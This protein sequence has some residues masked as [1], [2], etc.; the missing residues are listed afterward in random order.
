MK[1]FDFLKKA[2]LADWRFR[3]RILGVFLLI[4]FVF[5]FFYQRLVPFGKT[6]YERHWPSGW[7]SGKYSITA[8]RP[9]VRL[10]GESDKEYLRLVG[11]PLYFS[12]SSPR[13][14]DKARVTVEYYDHLPDSSPLIEIG[15]VKD[16]SSGA[17][18]I[19]P[20]QN[21]IIDHLASSWSSVEAAGFTIWQRRHYY[22]SASDFEKDLASSSLRDCPGGLSDCLALYNYSLPDQPFYSFNST[23][24]P[25]SWTTPLRGSH[26]LYVYLDNPNWRFDFSFTLLDAAADAKEATVSLYSGR[27]LKARKSVSVVSGGSN[28][29]LS[30]EN[31][32]AGLY[33]LE[34]ISDNQVEIS[35]I[36]S[37]SDKMSFINK[38]SLSGLSTPPPLFTD[39]D[40][41][42]LKT[43]NAE[44]LGPVYFAGQ[45]NAFDQ[46][47]T[48]FIFSENQSRFKKI[49]L[50]AGGIDL[51]GSGVFSW[52]PAAIIN[53][54]LTKLDRYFNPSSSQINYI[55]AAYKQP[56]EKNG[57]MRASASFDLKGLL[58]INGKYDFLISI[59]GLDGKQ[60]DE[61]YLDIRSIKI[62]LEGKSLWQ[63]ILS[64]I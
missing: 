30:G 45:E 52:S 22:S 62:E 18:D 15:L 39:I 1:I 50:P 28:L 47:Y 3:F 2:Y 21:K 33:R 46:V 64:L 10:A 24:Q 51:E 58:R 37:P 19:K 13:N 32:P 55:L 40:N 29:S 31:L 6:S 61:R 48:Q 8:F 56:E 59:P 27:E 23:T 42:H 11:D 14:F 44:S 7:H 25:H 5:F 60:G 63:K 57:L 17:I 41:L 4:L 12:L 49:V 36:N 16:S 43:V 35:Q 9:A 20:L 38:L 34:I 54:G 26:Q 53:P